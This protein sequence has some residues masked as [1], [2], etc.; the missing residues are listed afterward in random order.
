M[1][2]SLAVI[3]CAFLACAHADRKAAPDPLEVACAAAGGR[4]C[5]DLGWKTL[6]GPA[7]ASADRAAA[8]LFM[9]GCE[10]KD[11]QSCAD[12]GAMYAVGR[13]VRQDDG[14]A[15]ALGIAD[16]CA[17]AGLQ[18]PADARAPT[19]T[20]APSGAAFGHARP[21]DAKETAAAVEHAA[22]YARYF[23]ARDLHE[24]LGATR[25]ALE[26]DPPAPEDD[27]QLIRRVASLRR[28]KVSDCL[29]V[30]VFPNQDASPENAW[31]SFGIGSDGRTRSVRVARTSKYASAEAPERC[32]A[33]EVATWEF[34]A[35]RVGGRIWLLVSG[36]GPRREV[37]PVASTTGDGPV[38]GMEGYTK[39]AMAKAGCVKRGIAVPPSLA[40]Q[41]STFPRQMLVKF[42]IGS[43]G[44]ASRFQVM[45]P[46][47]APVKL[48]RVIEEAVQSC[49]WIPGRDPEGRPVE[50]W[51]VLPLRF[52]SG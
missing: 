36:T 43:G 2:R 5:R 19:E 38:Y 6:R 26:A 14:R 21:R 33:D 9:E 35:P 46:T 32:I 44:D 47:D 51:V 45:S 10:T 28:W 17:R 48:A 52:T 41:R 12:L 4:A 1:R 11:A 37:D 42:A 18:V 16:A 40:A 23:I 13:G 25:A 8:R 39:P 15:C 27:F 50:I 34:P 29:P 7:S 49:R 22:E 20:V 3:S 24:S 31:V 30:Y